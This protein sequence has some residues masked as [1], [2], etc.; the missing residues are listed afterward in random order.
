MPFTSQSAPIS[1]AARNLRNYPDPF[2]T[3][4]STLLPRT[5]DEML[6]WCFPPGTPILMA[7]GQYKPIEEIEFGDQVISAEGKPVDVYNTHTWES[8]ESNPESGSVDLVN[9]KVAGL[10]DFTAKTTPSHTL[11]VYRPKDNLS[12]FSRQEDQ[13]QSIPAD[14]VQEGD[15]LYTPKLEFEDKSDIDSDYELDGLDIYT[16]C[17]VGTYATFGTKAEYASNA[18]WAQTSGVWYEF[19]DKLTAERFYEAVTRYINSHAK[20]LVESESRPEVH[21]VFDS[22]QSRCIHVESNNL[23]TAIRKLVHPDGYFAQ[24]AFKLNQE[25]RRGLFSGATLYSSDRY[26]P[27]SSDVS[28]YV[29]YLPEYK[30]TLATQLIPIAADIHPVSIR[31]GENNYWYIETSSAS[32][33]LVRDGAVFRKINKVWHETYKGKLHNISTTN[34]HTY[35]TVFGAVD[36]CESLWFRNP[37]YARASKRIVAY[38]LTPVKVYGCSDSEAER[39]QNFLN[40]TLDVKNILS[41]LG[42][43]FMAYGNSFSS[44]IIPF[45][46]MLRCNHC[47]REMPLSQINY[48]FNNGNFRWNCAQCNHSNST[49]KPVDRRT[50]DVTKIKIKRW[51][52]HEIRIQE[53]P[54]TGRKVYYWEPPA[55]D[56]TRIRKGDKFYLED[57][58]WEMIEAVLAGKLFEFNDDV[59]FHMCEEGLAGLHTGGWG[60]PNVLE[61]FQQ[62]YYVQL[63]KLYNEVLFQEYIVPFRAITPAQRAQQQSDPL[64]TGNM[65]GF[66][67]QILNMLEKHRANPGGWYSLPFPIEYQSLGG[68][69]MEVNTYDHINAANDELLNA[70]GI[71]AELYKGTLSMQTLPT[72]LRLFEQSWPHLTAG[73]NNWL[74]WLMRQLSANFNWE[75][76]SAKLQPVTWADDAERRQILLQMM[77]A[78]KVSTDTVLQPLGIDHQEELEKIMDE[79]RQSMEAEQDFAQEQQQ[80]QMMQQYMNSSAL[81]ASGGMPVG[82]GGVQGGGP[83][84]MP[85]GGQASITP[86]DMKGQARQIA[87]QLVQMPYSQ[88]RSELSK[89]RKSSDTMHALVKSEMQELRSSAEQKGKNMILQGPQPQPSMEGA[90]SGQS[91][92]ASPMA[93]SGGGAPQGP[94]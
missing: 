52:P 58:P 23:V 67:K 74:D 31:Q 63:G 54:I 57:Y 85:G 90:T 46:R 68:E 22:R 56:V 7:D 84:G 48:S 15:F 41:D 17:L 59:I 49:N 62:A 28:T 36:N 78:G 75:K 91:A 27:V 34:D 76:A 38:F 14:Q 13:I 80:K 89:I 51:N 3:Y 45:K 18:S 30:D 65:G 71:P 79:R 73:F 69:G 20:Y 40:E 25:L 8:S 35:V 61:A 21:K 64:H 44:V 81:Q 5:V 29:S 83:G 33:R 86:D 77:A 1:S 37:T 93:T 50:K 88:R 66:N 19:P 16:A 60:I 12:R 6:R 47:S 55:T 24:E 53:H 43:D 4:S 11:K 2:N 94:M 9:L 82:A 32:D 92:P 10:S 70:I 39:Y 26:D 42:E 72:A 87:Q